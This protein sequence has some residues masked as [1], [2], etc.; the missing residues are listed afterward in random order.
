MDKVNLIKAVQVCGLVVAFSSLSVSAEMCHPELHADIFVDNE[1]LVIQNKSNTFRIGPKGDLFF[2]VHKV[3]LNDSQRASL[4]A[5][6]H[7]IRNDLPFISHTFSQELYTAW[8]ALDKII[9][10]ELGDKSVLRGELG[11]FHKHLQRRLIS[12]FYDANRFTHFNHQ[13]LSEAVIEFEESAPQLIAK[14]SSRGLLDIALLSEGEANKMQFISQKMAD[15]QEQLI[16]EVTAQRRRSQAIQ[17][18]VCN[19]LSLWQ[20]QEET[21]SELIPALSGW[22]TVTVR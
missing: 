13:A 7:T 20:T 22:K 2:D 4:T 6:N 17:K 5:Y 9:A 8:Q 3:A 15:L 14:V 12:S 1:S 19:R 10:L 16:N 18:E 21:I 11:E